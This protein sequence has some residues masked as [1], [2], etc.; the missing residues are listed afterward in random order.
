M[1]LEVKFGVPG[2]P[3]F[4]TQMHKPFPDPDTGFTVS[5][6]A[7][8]WY[9]RGVALADAGHHRQALTCFE[10][11]LALCPEHIGAWVFQGVA[12]I[13]LEQFEEALSSCDQALRLNPKEQEAWTFRGVALHRLSRFREA[14]ASYD[15]A[16]GLRRPK[17]RQRRLQGLKR[18]FKLFVTNRQ[19]C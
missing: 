13:H 17:V 3:H 19:S 14:Y 12:L 9:A 18:F 11:T 5:T 16:L 10:R 2:L 1:G 8:S 7:A 4:G 6:D 15:R